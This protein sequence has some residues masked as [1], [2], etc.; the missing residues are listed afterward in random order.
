MDFEETLQM[1]ENACSKL[2]GNR[3]DNN[4]VVRSATKIYLANL[5]RKNLLKKLQKVKEDVED[6]SYYTFG[7]QSV[8]QEDVLKIL[9]ELIENVKV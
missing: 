2:Y 5:P 9:D 6:L 4:E 3:I 7:G 1:V 8:P